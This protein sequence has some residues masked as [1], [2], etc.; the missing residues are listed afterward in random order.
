MVYSHKSFKD[1]LLALISLV[2]RLF[3]ATKFMMSASSSFS[4]SSGVSFNIGSVSK[5][6]DASP[7]VALTCP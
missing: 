2:S 3:S 5:S 4:F 6:G 1:F 7:K